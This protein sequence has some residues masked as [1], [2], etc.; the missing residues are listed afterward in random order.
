[1]GPWAQRLCVTYLIFGFIAASAAPRAQ[2]SAECDS[3]LLPSAQ[4]IKAGRKVRQKMASDLKRWGY[5]DQ[6]YVAEW[7]IPDAKNAG[8][9][10]QEGETLVLGVTTAQYDDWY[11]KIGR[12]SIGLM[13]NGLP[14]ENPGSAFIRIGN[15]WMSDT[16]IQDA[17]ALRDLRRTIQNFKAKKGLTE[18]TFL[19]SEEEM[20]A[21]MK[22]FDSRRGRQ[23]RAQFDTK[24]VRKGQ[25]INPK[26]AHTGDDLKLESCAAACTS[27]VSDLWLDHYEEAEVLRLLRERL[28]LN[29]TF[30]AR[31]MLWENFRNPSAAMMTEFRIERSSRGL[32]DDFRANNGWGHIRGLYPYAYIPDGG[33]EHATSKYK[34]RRL[35]LDE[36]L[37]NP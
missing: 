16:V 27:F 28:G 19:L 34:S 8:P 24:D 22:F 7:S 20:A 31:R 4:Q 1:M 35:T 25:K 15:L 9:F 17:V 18:V 3:L 14:E 26:Y 29:S 23:I 37:A 13:L 33:L 30:V 32:Q 2:K 6:A 21:V 36:Y 11:E 5:A 12:R 10:L